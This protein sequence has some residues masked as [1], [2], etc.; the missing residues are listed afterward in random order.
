MI[1][2]TVSEPAADKVERVA[3]T[4]ESPP[5]TV[6][7]RTSHPKSFPWPLLLLGLVVAGVV[8]ATILA[9]R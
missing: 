6:A 7:P 5:S 8:V 4:E 2:G 9:M 3:K 1:G